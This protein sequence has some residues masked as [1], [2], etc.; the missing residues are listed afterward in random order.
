V[1]NNQDILVPQDCETFIVG[2]IN[3]E[4]F[5]KEFIMVLPKWDGLHDRILVQT[6]LINRCEQG[7]SKTI[8]F[9]PCRVYDGLLVLDGDKLNGFIRRYED[10]Y[11]I[12]S[13]NDGYCLVFKIKTNKE[14]D[15][16][17]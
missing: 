5:D 1:N 4:A 13:L 9:F 15:N 17:Q 2:K 12:Q 7:T 8:K 10:I 3:K 14:K 11:L 16:G 6:F